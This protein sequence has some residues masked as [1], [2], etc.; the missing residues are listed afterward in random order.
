MRVN[1]IAKFSNN[2]V[3]IGKYL[4]KYFL[5][6]HCFKSFAVQKKELKIMKLVINFLIGN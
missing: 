1:L 3:K 2:P 4:N 6:F 5:L